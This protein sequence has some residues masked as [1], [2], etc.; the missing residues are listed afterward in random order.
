M[1]KNEFLLNSTCTDTQLNLIELNL[2][3]SID[4]RID[5]L[6]SSVSLIEEMRK[7]LNKINENRL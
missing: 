5:Q 1:E 4:E 7:S 2:E 3:L 6:Q